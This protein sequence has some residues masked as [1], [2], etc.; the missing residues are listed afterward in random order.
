VWYDEN[1]SMF[2]NQLGIVNYANKSKMNDFFSY[3]KPLVYSDNIINGS[4]CIEISFNALET[5]LSALLSEEVLLFKDQSAVEKHDDKKVFIIEFLNKT[6][7]LLVP[8]KPIFSQFNIAKYIYFFIGSSIVM[9]IIRRHKRQLIGQDKQHQHVI[10]AFTDEK[11]LY[12]QLLE[13]HHGTNY[14]DFIQQSIIDSIFNAFDQEIRSLNLKV[15]TSINEEVYQ[16]QVNI[17]ALQTLLLH[18]MGTTIA[19]I[20][21]NGEISIKLEAK[22]DNYIHCVY[23]NNRYVLDEESRSDSKEVTQSSYFHYFQLTN[24]QLICFIEKHHIEI[25]TEVSRYQGE[26]MLIKLPFNQTGKKYNN[27]IK[28]FDREEL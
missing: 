5:Y 12:C 21:K 28:L 1:N 27:V 17:F 7:W 20:Q 2:I 11:R 18:F 13:Y 9:L 4:I 16:H 22:D 15:V 10:K 23:S 6:A 3:C 14:F 24:K 8:D 19:N 25:V 26:Q